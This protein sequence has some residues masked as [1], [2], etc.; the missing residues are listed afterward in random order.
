MQSLII[1]TRQSELAL[2][3]ANFV[4]TTLEQHYPGITITLLPMTTEGDRFLATALNKIGGKGLFIKELETALLDGRA[5]IAVHS[6][7][8]LPAEL[9]E[10]LCLAAICEREDPRDALVS[11]RFM[12][13]AALPV[14]ARIGSS[15]LRRQCQI[16]A[17]RPDLQ[18]ELLRGNVPTRLKRLDAKEFDA[19][20]LAAA[21]LI[22]LGFRHRISQY[23]SP[24]ESL[25]AVGQGALGIECRAQDVAM[26]QLLA[27]LSHPQTQACVRAERAV[28]QALHGGCHVPLAAY[29][30]IANDHTHLQ[31]RALIGAP[32]GTQ[33][34]QTH[35]Y[36]LLQDAE[37]LGQQA[38]ADLL[39]QGGANLLGMDNR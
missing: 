26:Q 19:I 24:E 10:D 2:W 27:V 13:L 6:M 14:G 7:K 23:L 33:I 15:S 37:Q 36:G 30:T 32:D 31:L 18:I 29:A 11:T 16:K 8:D 34:I 35:A 5:D 38:A 21:G 25:P 28:N 12:S 20:I 9:P 3:Q 22:R 1:A 17:L 39:R 4:K